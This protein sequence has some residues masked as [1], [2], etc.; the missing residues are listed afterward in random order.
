M[1]TAHTEEVTDH[2]L[3]RVA[4]A[5][6]AFVGSKPGLLLLGGLATYVL[7]PVLQNMADDRKARHAAQVET[8]AQFLLYAN[9]RWDEIALVLPMVALGTIDKPAYLKFLND[10]AVIKG[11]RYEAY[12]KVK[13]LSLNFRT[14]ADR[15]AQDVDGA[16]NDYAGAINTYSENINAWVRNL[17]CLN[18][19]CANVSSNGLDPHFDP[20]R[21]YSELSAQAVKLLD[22]DDAVQEVLNRAIGKEKAWPYGFKA[23]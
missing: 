18:Y 7:V 6:W 22:R 2:W 21:A 11:K 19:D 4:K 1:T 12:A 8:V 10:E 16:L 17:Y 15:P 5:L 9:S 3:H 13:A 23:F 20:N 14:R